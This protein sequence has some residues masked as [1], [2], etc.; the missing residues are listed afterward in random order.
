MATKTIA[1]DARVYEELAAHKRP[2][3]SFSKAIHR[4]LRGDARQGTAAAIL[5]HLETMPPLPEEDSQAMLDVVREN[6]EQEQW[7]PLD[8]S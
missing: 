7:K 8:L 6:R 3:E 2:G 1:V 4:I 5:E